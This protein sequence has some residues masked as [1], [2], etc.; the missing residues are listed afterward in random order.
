M[1]YLTLAALAIAIPAFGQGKPDRVIG[2]GSVW[3]A[4]EEPC[5]VH[6][7]SSSSVNAGNSSGGVWY[8]ARRFIRIGFYSMQVSE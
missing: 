2:G 5:W 7:D 1:K 4:A 3:A 8:A 6:D